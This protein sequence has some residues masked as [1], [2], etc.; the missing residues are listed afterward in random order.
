[1]SLHDIDPFYH[2]PTPVGINGQDF[3]SLSPVSTRQNDHLITRS[4]LPNCHFLKYLRR[5]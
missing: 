4:N 5:Q 2:N 3:T 1:M